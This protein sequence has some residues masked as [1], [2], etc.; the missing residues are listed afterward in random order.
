VDIMSKAI[1]RDKEGG[2]SKGREFQLFSFD[3]DDFLNDIYPFKHLQRP[4][5]SARCTP[6]RFLAISGE[7][8]IHYQI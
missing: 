3:R 2:E 8:R 7:K 5:F 6:E 4:S 1:V